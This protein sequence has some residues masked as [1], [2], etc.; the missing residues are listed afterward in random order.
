MLAAALFG[1]AAQVLFYGH[2]LGAN[3]LLAALVFLLLGWSIRERSI[4][5][6]DAWIPAFAV[7]FGALLAARTEPAVAVF[8]ALALVALGLASATALGGPVTSL[9]FVRLV[10]LGAAVL[11]AAIVRA[12]DA[13]SEERSRP[14]PLARLSPA[15]PYVAGIA[16]AIPFLAVFG[17]LFTSADEVFA[18]AMREAFQDWLDALRDAPGRVL[19]AAICAWI[20]GGSFTLLR[21]E[22]R[23]VPGALPGR[24]RGETIVVLLVAIDVLFASFVAIQLTYL[25]GGRDTVDAA[26]I[27]YSAYG[28]HG[29]FEL[30]GVAVLVA[31]L[32]FVIE[33]VARSRPRAYPIAALALIALTGVILASAAFRMDLYQHAYGWSELRFHAFGAMA[34]LALAL[35]IFAWAVIARRMEFAVQPIVLAALSVAV[36][37]NLIG[38]SAFVA[39]ANIARVVDPSGLPADAERTLDVRYL[40]TLGDAALPV[41]VEAVPSLPARE[42]DCV[43]AVLRW[44]LA[45]RDL[46]APRAWQEWNWDRERAL[47]ALRSFAAEIPASHGDDWR[48]DARLT[49]RIA[50]AFNGCPWI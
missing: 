3:A 41:L 2:L 23:A 50:A 20:A 9:P 4:D 13:V 18:H 32:L 10:F 30:V 28:R 31:G 12:W 17:A 26:G 45:R 1:A 21:R 29:F 38:P 44:T 39:R 7:I 46:G 33:L 42:R 37:T 43:D 47:A 34:F 14:F 35:A 27:A 48:G 36:A 5:P 6:R 8:D 40:Y 19:L 24:L 16:L 25:F 11:E 49:R 15:A 22:D